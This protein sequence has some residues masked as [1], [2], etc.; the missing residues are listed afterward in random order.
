ME[1]AYQNGE[2]HPLDLKKA[3]GDCLIEILSPVREYIR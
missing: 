3:C 2:V 1:Q